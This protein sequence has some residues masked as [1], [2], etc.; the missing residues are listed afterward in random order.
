MTALVLG[1]NALEVLGFRIMHPSGELVNT[2]GKTCKSGVVQTDQL[3]PVSEE[4]VRVILDQTVRV[5][6]FQS[7]VVKASTV[8]TSHKLNARNV[9]TRRPRV[10]H[11]CIFE[12]TREDTRVLSLYSKDITMYYQDY[13]YLGIVYMSN[14][15]IRYA[16]RLL[17]I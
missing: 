5:G 3:G 2:T 4:V 8:Q 14:A 11:A 13:I 9:Y 16:L 7:K 6:P 10:R 1:T 15:L 12:I 17:M